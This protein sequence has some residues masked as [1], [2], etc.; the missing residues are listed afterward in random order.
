MK[1]LLGLSSI[2]CL[3]IFFSCSNE[4]L[5]GP[6]APQETGSAKINIFVGKI[7]SLAKTAKTA[8]IT[9]SRLIINLS[10]PDARALHDTIPL[11]GN[12][13]T[14][15]PLTYDNLASLKTWTLS[16]KTVDVRDSIIHSASTTFLVEPKQT[17][18]VSLSLNARFSMLTAN[19]FPI[20]DSVTR[21][22]LSVDGAVK[23][24]SLFVKQTLIG[25]TVKLGFDYLSTGPQHLVRLNVFGTMWG[26]DTLLYTCD[27]IITAAAGINAAYS[28]TLKWVGP[29]LPPPGQATMRVVIGPVGTVV[30]NGT[31]AAG[32]PMFHF[33]AR[34]SGRCPYSGPQD[35]II[36]WTYATGTEMR[37][38]P[39]IDKNGTIYIGADDNNLYAVNPDGSRK[40]TFA[41]SGMVRSSPAIADNGTIYA[42]SLDHSLYAVNQTG[43]LKW[44]F[45][46]DGEVY[47]SPTIGSDGT[48]FFGSMDGKL[49]ALNPDGSLKGSF[50]TG[51]GIVA[52]PAI[53]DD[54]T[55]Y[56]GSCNLNI[57]YAINPDFSLKWKTDNHS[58]VLVCSPV[59][60]PAGTA[61]YYGAQDGYL[62]ARNTA[63][64]S[65]KW[66]R[67]AYGGWDGTPAVGADGTLYVGNSWGELL[68]LNPE[69][70]SAKW[71][72]YMTL[73][74]ESSPCVGADGTIY[75][76]STYGGLFALN[77]DGTESWRIVNSNAFGNIYSSPVLGGDGRMYVGYSNGLL[78][79]GKK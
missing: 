66:K 33:D 79:I 47:S 11:R 59:L 25:D 21:C 17:A 64:G 32:W 39:A 2:F 76:S 6:I 13:A 60:S 15:V 49:Y 9:L 50:V 68:A 63:D 7:G 62:Y 56:I 28:V 54:G 36:T 26:F 20:R 77:P 40:W 18:I 58:N 42:G 31:L 16:A 53:G 29:A 67:Y 78:S 1:R 75:F 12:G 19:F 5:A 73:S 14:S 27:T 72:D 23:D 61:V 71:D 70:G 35:T 43:T 30:I 51:G 41:T 48:I 44:S 46:T 45:L 57:F 22:Q 37:S 3:F 24:D 34:H 10:A 69:D 4:K 74:V 52:S 65:L 38:S 8:D 55:I